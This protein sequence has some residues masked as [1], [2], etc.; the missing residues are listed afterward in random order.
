METGFLFTTAVSP[1]VPKIPIPNG[2]SDHEVENLV[3][4]ETNNGNSL[5]PLKQ[6]ANEKV[7]IKNKIKKDVNIGKN[8]Q[9]L[10]E[11]LINNNGSWPKDVIELK[12]IENQLECSLLFNKEVGNYEEASII[13]R[14]LNRVSKTIMS[15]EKRRKNR[16]E[17]EKK[18]IEIY[19][20]IDFHIKQWNQQYNEFLEAIE[21]DSL[22]L[23]KKQELEIEEF[24]KSITKKPIYLH[25]KVIPQI[26]YLRKREK[27]LASHRRYEEAT[28]TQKIADL[29]S[30]KQEEL[31]AN[32]LFNNTALKREE[33]EK[34]HAAQIKSFLSHAESIQKTMI[35]SR[36][37]LIDGLQKRLDT[38]IDFSNQPDP[39]Q[40]QNAIHFEQSYPIPRYRCGSSFATIRLKNRTVDHSNCI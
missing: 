25:K 22:E 3:I 2:N 5:K 29:M 35:K 26:P 32:D 33:L 1:N 39:Q 18:N 7:I 9:D 31:S 27:I 4:N 30:Q 34:K 14:L 15:E 16:V 20:I 21:Y 40:N 38:I 13:Q 19:S 8:N 37:S 36:N 10:V 6:K 12:S 24:E 23:K 11:F 28:E 17:K